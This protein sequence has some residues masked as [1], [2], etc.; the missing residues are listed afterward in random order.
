MKKNNSLRIFN[1]LAKR[2]YKVSKKRKLGW[3]WRDCQKW[4]SAN[5]FKLY[6][7]KPISK[8]KVTEVDSV[9]IGILDSTG[10]AQVPVTT[11]Q[12]EVCDSVFQIPTSDLEPVNWWNFPDVVNSFPPLVNIDIQLPP[13]I[14]TGITKRNILPDLNR[15]REDF[16]KV[17]TS[18]EII[19]VFKILVRPKRKDDGSNCSYYILATFEDSELDISTKDNEIDVFVSEE[20]LSAETKAKRKQIEL[21][22]EGE[23]KVNKKVIQKKERPQQVETK[24]ASEEK[25][26]LEAERYKQLNIALDGLR[27]DFKLGLITKKQYQARQQ[28]LLKKFENGGKI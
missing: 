13:F 26:S 6:K 15:V 8:I 16:R 4:T 9:V 22:K 2:V 17:K 25:I 5:L 20:D 18:S 28:I 10:G 27:E 11:P 23:K 3:T 21:Q 19:I 14:N 24:S 12:K 7:G 1:L